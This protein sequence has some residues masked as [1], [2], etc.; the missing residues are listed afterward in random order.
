MIAR[1]RHFCFQCETM[2]AFQRH[3]INDRLHLRLTIFTLGVWG[4]VWIIL[5]LRPSHPWRC[6]YC[7]RS[8]RSF[9]RR[10]EYSARE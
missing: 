3:A 8:A 1:C 7:G 5:H 4:A 6:G 2:R 10:F 9:Q